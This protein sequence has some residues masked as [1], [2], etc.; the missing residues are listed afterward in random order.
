M[1]SDNN[2]L[3]FD[4][5]KASLNEATQRHAPIKQQYIRANH[6]PYKQNVKHKK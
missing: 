6:A 3:E 5:F 4:L 2:D 1:P